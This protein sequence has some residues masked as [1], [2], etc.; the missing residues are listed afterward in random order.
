MKKSLLLITCAV[1]ALSAFGQNGQLPPVTFPSGT[2]S[3]DN[4]PW[5]LVFQ[6]DFNGTQ[7]SPPWITFNSWLGMPG[8]DND[9]WS[10]GRVEGYAILKD[11]NV[12]VSNGTAKILVKKEPASWHCATC[13][14]NTVNTN[15]TNGC[16]HIPFTKYFNAGK[17]EASIKM[18]TFLWAHSTFWLWHGTTVNEIDMAEAYGWSGSSGLFGYYPKCDYSLHAW[19]PP[20]GQNP[21]N[22]QH[23]EI[24]NSYPNQSW[25]DWVTGHYFKQDQFHTYTCTWDTSDVT[26]YL[27]GQLINQQWKYY[28]DRSVTNGF[29]P[30]R[31]TVNYRVGSYCNPSG[32]WKVLPGFPYNNQSYSALNISAYVDKEDSR[33]QSGLLGQTEV[34]YVKV[35]QKHP[36]NT[37]HNICDP[38]NSTISGPSIICNTATFTANP[39]SPSGYWLAPSS[40]LTIL[41]SNNASITVQKNSISSTFDGYVYY[42]PLNPDC[43]NTNS[44]FLE[45]KRVDVGTAIQTSVICAETHSS[46]YNTVSY[47]LHADP[48]YYGSSTPLSNYNSPTSFEWFID[49]GQNYSQSYH[50]FGQFVSTPTISYTPSTTNPIRWTLII[51]NACGI[52]RKTGQMSFFMLKKA[53]IDGSDTD[54]NN[55]YAVANVT[56][57]DAYNDAVTQ[58]MAQTFL[59]DTADETTVNETFERMQMEELAPYLLFDS[60]DV[61]NMN[62]ARR[63]NNNNVVVPETR[64]YPNPSSRFINIEPSEKYINKSIVVS[65]YDLLG[66]LK[67]KIEYIY[68]QG[69]FLSIDISILSTGLYNVELRQNGIAEHFKVMKQ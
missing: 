30:F 1:F 6:D 26:N 31:H 49:Y 13:T 66:S 7:L 55:L 38:A 18:P 37:W 41:S 59:V 24:A 48:N 40:N 29:W 23:V 42:Y 62:V 54:R 32:T 22:M 68:N 28:Q 64:V 46:Q 15:Y 9:N 43:P 60:T 8:G 14:M 16:L 21:Y 50:G 47:N 2:N 5:Q 12:V 61:S 34:D 67:I 52:V 65:V 45:W 27:D 33:H 51:T 63:A 17:F 39:P 4:S 58:R 10:E 35:W 44:S 25:W 11:E 69:D 20:N 19:N 56:D 36:D 53:P 3:C 57:V